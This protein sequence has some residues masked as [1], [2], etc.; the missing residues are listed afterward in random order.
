LAASLRPTLRAIRPPPAAPQGPRVE[1][2][3]LP[4]RAKRKPNQNPNPKP[5]TE[6]KTE[7]KARWTET[8]R[9]NASSKSK[10]GS[11]LQRCDSRFRFRCC[12][13]CRS[14]SRSSSRSSSC[15]QEPALFNGAP[16]ERREVVDQPAGAPAGMP[17]MFVT[18]Q[19]WPVHE[20]PRTHAY[21]KRRDA[22]RAR[23]RGGLSLAYF[24][25]ATQREVGRAARRA[26]RRLLILLFAS[27]DEA[28]K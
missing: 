3:L 18:G 20:D 14:C 1:R 17:A 24:S 22:R 11:S 4:A 5:A 15:G 21:P 6:T 9:A 16:G 13:R 25:L 8:L 7:P 28:T 26:D 27:N 10:P 19:G 2:G 12:C 23:T